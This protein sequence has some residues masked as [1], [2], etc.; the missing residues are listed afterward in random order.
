MRKGRTRLAKKQHH[1]PHEEHVDESWLIPYADLLTLLLAL[2]IVLFAS[3]SVDAKKFNA[4][5]E[6]FNEAFTGNSL[7]D[8]MTYPESTENTTIKPTDGET[9]G[10]LKGKAETALQKESRE[11]TELKKQ[12]D[13]YIQ[14][15]NLSTELNTKLTEQFLIITISDQALFDSGSA[16]LKSSAQRNVV[17]I[18]SFI[19]KYPQYEVIVSGHTDNQPIKNKQFEDNWHLST[20]RALN[21]LKILLHNP[22]LSPAR[23]SAIGYGE[24]RP[25]A[26][27]DSTQGRSKNRRVEVAI[28]RNAI[29]IK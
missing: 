19:S 29:Q 5:M 16:E 2:F 7:I 18:A 20:E 24:Y 1:Q 17:S 3:S 22:K 25:V 12:L 15:Q 23:L 11:L 21:V 9:E 27:N 26:S 8:T 28:K 4:M 10:R 14:Q 6:T 13:Q